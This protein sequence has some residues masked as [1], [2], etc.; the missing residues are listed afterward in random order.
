MDFFSYCK[1]YE[2]A[3]ELL[4]VRNNSMI[5]SKLDLIFKHIKFLY[6]RNN[7]LS[8]RDV[9]SFITF[10]LLFSSVMFA[11]YRPPIMPAY[12]AT[13]CS[14]LPISAVKANGEQ[15]TNPASE[16]IDNNQATR[17]S[18][19]GLG[20]WIRLDLGSQKMVCSVDITWFSGNTRQNTFTIAVSNDGNSF[21]NVFSGK[22]SGTTT[23]AERY[24]F[25]DTQARYVRIKVTANTQNDW[26]SITEIDVSGAAS[27]STCCPS[28]SA[29]RE[30]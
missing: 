19:E 11:N 2:Y 14:N 3:S 8:Y 18:N 9:L 10:S 12:S 30:G 22:S 23:A 16:A 27:S 13:S 1:K 5:I 4:L 21:S 29:S 6:N 17:W 15:S 7:M 28:L 26:V 25:T 24:D 20:S